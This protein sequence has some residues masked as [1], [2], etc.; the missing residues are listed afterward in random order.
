VSYLARLKAKIGTEKFQNTPGTEPTKPTELGFGGFVGSPSGLSENFQ[1]VAETIARPGIPSLD[2][3]RAAIIEFEAGV[4]RE[5]AEGYARL[6]GQPVRAGV[7]PARWRVFLDDCGR[8]LD[9][10]AAR[11]DALGWQAHDL[12]G[13]SE[14]RPAVRLDL[15]GLAW[16]LDGRELVALTDMAAAIRTR[17]GSIQHYY[18][19]QP[20]PGQR[21]A[22][23]LKGEA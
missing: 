4:P 18:R 22:W 17:S 21:L 14:N 11:A 13:L 16:L 1:G 10:W 3:E 23:E 15:A 19:I 12:F 7:E 6:L 2:H 5:W 9:R 20:R 8:F